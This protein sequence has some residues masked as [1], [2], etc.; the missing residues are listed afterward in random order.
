MHIVVAGDCEKHDFILAAAILL[1]SYFNNE[2]MIISDNSRNYQYFEGEVS[3]IKIA[4]S[5]V[6]DK[7]DI[8]LYDWHHGYP[9][10]LEE[11]I[12]V[13]ATTYDRQAMENVNKLLD[14]KRMPTVLLVIEE[15]CGLGLKYVDKY[16]PVI[17]SKISYISSPER[18]INWVHDGR[19]DLKVDKD[20]AEAV[21]DF[22]IEICDVPKQDIKKLWQYARKRG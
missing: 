6:A 14:Q 18:R 21:N 20:F 2:V 16:Y 8:V 12:I 15:E 19:V 4:D 11:E 9:E 10:G 17:T 13:F 3:G 22:L 7:P 5:T 1:K